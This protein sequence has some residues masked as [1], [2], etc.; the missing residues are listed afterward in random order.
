MSDLLD[1]TSTI[2]EQLLNMRLERRKRYTGA[3]LTHC[4]ECG[5]EIPVARREA[6]P[7]CRKCVHCASGS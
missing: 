2:E 7:G 3:A 6:V 1:D 5:D 4:V